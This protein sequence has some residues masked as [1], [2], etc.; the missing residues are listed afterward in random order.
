MKA[1][2]PVTNTIVTKLKPAKKVWPAVFCRRTMGCV[3]WSL[4]HTHLFSFSVRPKFI[5][6]RMEACAI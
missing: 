4:D 5:V 6:S 3:L 2:I 1:L